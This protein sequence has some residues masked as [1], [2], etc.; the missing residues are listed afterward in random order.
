MICIEFTV[1]TKTELT[2]TFLVDVIN[3]KIK[4]IHDGKKTVD[5]KWFPY[6]ELQGSGKVGES[7]TIVW[8]NGK[9]LKSLPLV[10]V[11]F[12]KI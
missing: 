3:S 8:K 11:S 12:P 10:S 5:A 2:N 4:R 6:Q 1:K 7:L 9:R